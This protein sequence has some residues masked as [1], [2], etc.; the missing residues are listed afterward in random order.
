MRNVKIAQ[1]GSVLI[2]LI[3]TMISMGTLGTSMY[4]LTSTSTFGTLFSNKANQALLLAEA[5]IRYDQRASLA[6]GTVTVTL[7]SGVD[8]FIVTKATDT[9]TGVKTTISTGIAGA[10]SSWPVRKKITYV[11]GSPGSSG[12]GAGKPAA[13]PMATVAGGSGQSTGTFGIGDHHGNAGALNVTGATGN[14]NTPQ[15]YPEAYG[16]PT[17]TTNPFCQPWSNMGNYLSYDVQIK[18]AEEH[19][20]PNEWNS[21]TAYYLDDLVWYQTQTNYFVCQQT[22]CTTPPSGKKTGW[23]SVVYVYSLGVLFRVTQLNPQT[24]AYGITYFRSTLYTDGGTP[25]DG[26]PAT[27]MPDNL[28]DN[29]PAILLFTR[30]GNSGSD[31][32]WLAY[33]P[34]GGT[35]HVVDEYGFLKDWST[36]LVRVVEAASIK[37]SAT[38]ATN[39]N[40]G[41]QVTGGAGSAT[42][43]R[44]INDSDD[45]VILLLNTVNGSFTSPVT[46]GGQTYTTSNDWGDSVSIPTWQSDILYRVGD[47]VQRSSVNYRCIQQHTSA[48]SNRPD[49]AGGKA[50]WQQDTPS[51]SFYRQRDNYIWAFFADT[52]NHPTYNATATDNTRR[53]KDLFP[54]DLTNFSPPFPV[55]DVQAWTSADDDFTVATW[56]TGSSNLNTAVDSS[57]RLLG[58]GK[59]LNAIIRTN[60]WVTGSYP[61]NCSAFPPEIGI[62]SK[63]TTSMQNGYDDLA[64][65]ILHG[66]GVGGTP[67]AGYYG[68]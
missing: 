58:R 29:E 33:M 41:D 20:Q 26:V 31:N 9:A 59:E 14:I 36:I 10:N 34:L 43:I 30:D 17:W 45:G 13:V 23:V 42:I 22:T 49:G 46:V 44:K 1:R 11:S 56:A 28:P 64:Y 38:S 63:G 32:H 67:S 2:I 19:G 47:W 15:T 18:V 4:L 6:D 40:V 8:Q 25:I 27:M 24:N 53:E 61:T 48:S 16:T 66:A 50:Y 5:G 21:S 54:D 37:L 35:N 57:L 65:R 12:P 3:I 52:D 51:S 62:I 68:Y 60:R 55:T 39:I 7:N